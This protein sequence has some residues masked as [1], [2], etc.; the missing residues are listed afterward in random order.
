MAPVA[1][2]AASGL[3][4]L[5]THPERIGVAYRP[6]ADLRGGVVRGYATVAQ[7][8]VAGDARAWF[9]AAADAGS[10]GVLEAQVV[11]SALVVRP[12]LTGRRLVRV[13]LSAAALLSEPV[14]SALA[15]EPSLDHLVVELDACTAPCGALPTALGEL[16][17][18]GARVSADLSGCGVDGLAAVAVLGAQSVVADAGR[19]D[20]A[21]LFAG[22]A[23]L[24]MEHEP[25]VV[26]TGVDDDATLDAVLRGGVR[27]GEGDAL[28]AAATMPGELSRRVRTR[29]LSGAPDL[30]LGGLVVPGPVPGP[31]TLALPARTT[32]REAARRAMARPAT[33]RFDPIAVVAEDGAPVGVVPVDRLVAAL[34][35]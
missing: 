6:V 17:A 12:L 24:T 13:A 1:A 26:A 27:F 23:D 28:G 16:R 22:L 9:T 33:L 19:V 31:G 4:A 20:L 10:A 29:L 18:R 11:Q 15:A 21:A 35:G 3:H 25:R 5:L 34:A 8:P 7:L 30:D 14:W 2:P 32:L